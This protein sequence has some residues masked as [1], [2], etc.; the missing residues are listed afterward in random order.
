MKTLCL[1]PKEA[2]MFVELLKKVS[3][4]EKIGYDLKRFARYASQV[5][6][7]GMPDSLLVERMKNL[8]V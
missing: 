2:L 8:P 6:E 4:G 7:E 3:A 5:I 1:T